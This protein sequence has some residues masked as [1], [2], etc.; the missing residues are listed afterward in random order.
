MTTLLDA[1][2]RM[3]GIL[4]LCLINESKE[5]LDMRWEVLNILLVDHN[6]TH[7]MCSFAN[8]CNNV[9]VDSL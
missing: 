1:L 3:D 6:M 9:G 5:S 2:S 4:I 8:V 7:M